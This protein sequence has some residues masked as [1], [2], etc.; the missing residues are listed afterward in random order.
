MIE[1]PH[2]VAQQVGREM[3]QDLVAESGF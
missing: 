1:K 2:A 3:N